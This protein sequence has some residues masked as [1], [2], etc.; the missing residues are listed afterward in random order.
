MQGYN[1]IPYGV[2]YVRENYPPATWH[3]W[4]VTA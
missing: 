1:G 3:L 4:G 2:E